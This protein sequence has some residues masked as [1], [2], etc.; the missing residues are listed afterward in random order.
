M[1]VIPA[2]KRHRQKNQNIEASLSCIVRLYIKN[3]R[4]EDVESS[5]W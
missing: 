1:P 5:Q 4:A 2:L 3:V